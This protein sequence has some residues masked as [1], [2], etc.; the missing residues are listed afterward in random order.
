MDLARDVMR[1]ENDRVKTLTN[2]LSQ[3]CPAVCQTVP[4]DGRTMEET[5]VPD[6]VRFA[7]ERAVVACFNAIRKIARRSSLLDLAGSDELE[8][9]ID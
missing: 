7:R 6:N 5:A 2:L 9:M 4:E 1:A 3:M 8:S